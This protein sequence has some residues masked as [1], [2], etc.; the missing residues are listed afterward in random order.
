[1]AHLAIKS[2]TKHLRESY[3]TPNDLEEDLRRILLEFIIHS[4]FTLLYLIGGTAGPLRAGRNS[5]FHDVT[6]IVLGS[7]IRLEANI[8]KV[9]FM[10]L[11]LTDNSF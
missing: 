10:L 11:L 1:M 6:R 4:L 7:T 8:V 3:R 2:F 9:G 5:S